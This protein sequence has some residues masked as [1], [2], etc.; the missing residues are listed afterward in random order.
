MNRIQE[1]DAHVAAVI[2][3]ERRKRR[4]SR[5][6]LANV[7]GVSSAQM[8]KYEDGTNRISPGRLY[9]LAELMKMEVW[10]F[11]PVDPSLQGGEALQE[12]QA[13]FIRLPDDHTR[14]QL[15]ELVK[16]MAY[17]PRKAVCG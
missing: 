7:L 4:L 1:I 9:I 14:S 6:Q 5:Q 17:R 16:C 13:A 11:F 3:Q 8:Q 10:E 12:L 15:L 2:A